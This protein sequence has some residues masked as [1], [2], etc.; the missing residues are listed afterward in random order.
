MGGAHTVTPGVT[1]TLLPDHRF[2]SKPGFE[3][4]RPVKATGTSS[5]RVYLSSATRTRS[6]TPV[7]PPLV[8]PWTVQGVLGTDVTLRC[9]HRRRPVVV[10]L[11]TASAPLTC[12]KPLPEAASH[13]GSDQRVAGPTFD[14]FRIFM[15]VTVTFLGQERC[16]TSLSG[17]PRTRTPAQCAKPFS[18]RFPHLAG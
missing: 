17:E 9:A 5:Q 7:T 15:L 3:P 16:G 4:G 13:I 6:H 14:S 8:H 1:S 18:R 11:A 12:H 2:V 10:P